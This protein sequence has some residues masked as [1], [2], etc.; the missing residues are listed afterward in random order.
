MRD[1]V[2]GITAVDGRGKPF[3]GG[4][5]VV[6]NVAGYDFCKLL[7]GSLGTLGVI[8]QVTLRLKP[9]PQR[10][11]LVAARVKNTTEAERHLA[12]LIESTTT[13]VAIELLGGPAWADDPAVGEL[14]ASRDEALALAVGIEGSD[15]EVKWMLDTLRPR[16]ASPKRGRST[17][18]ARR[19]CSEPL[20]SGLAEFPQAR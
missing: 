14:L 8:T 4:G 19:R 7:T 11:A 3:K 13:P 5:R 16:V 12:A 2:I 17:R 15:D 1:Y 20:A 10:T 6:K 18:G 9:I